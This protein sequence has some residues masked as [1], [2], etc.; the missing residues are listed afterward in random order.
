MISLK[1]ILV[2][3][4][5]SD[6]SFPAFEFAHYLAKQCKAVLHVLHVYEPVSTNKYNSNHN[7]EQRFEKTRY[8]NAEE[9]LR[10]FI[11]KISPQGVEI[12][13]AMNP[14]KPFEQI[15]SY[16]KFNKIDLVIISSHGWTGLSHL[17]TGNVTNKIL[18]YSQVPTICIKSGRF[19]A[20]KDFHE[21]SSSVAENWVG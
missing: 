17:I 19:A 6:N 5:F 21:V 14:G 9:E 4:D 2:P 20:Y 10:R 3:T 16:T 11:N 7:V 13:E 12:V 8:L 18:R 1:N 15:L